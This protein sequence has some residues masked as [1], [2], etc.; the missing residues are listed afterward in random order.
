MPR[1]NNQ[2]QQLTSYNYYNNNKFHTITIASFLQNKHKSI[3]E[4]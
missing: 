3:G 4:L 2:P 1:K